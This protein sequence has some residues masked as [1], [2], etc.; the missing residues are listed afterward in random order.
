MQGTD[1]T[2]IGQWLTQLRL[3]RQNRTCTGP[4]FWRPFHFVSLALQMARTGG[5]LALPEEFV[6][7]ASRMGLWQAIGLPTP[8]AVNA[9]D[10]HG[11]FVPLQRLDDA[12]A[13]HDTSVVLAGICKAFGA[14]KETLSSL[15]IS[16][17]EIMDNC[18]AHAEI[19]PGGLQ[20]LACAQSWPRGNLAQ[21]AI[22]DAGV[23]VRASLAGN[24]LLTD[25]LAYENACDLA[26]Q[27]GVTSKPGMGH[28]GYGLALARQLL[29]ANGGMLLVQSSDEW[30]R[31]SGKNVQIGRSLQSWP[32]TL[33][34]LEWDCSKPLRAKDVYQSWPAPS[35]YSDD[36][37]E[38]PL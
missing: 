12:D 13:V 32:G 9:R 36:D 23:G 10:P 26:T 11:K 8:A 37:F 29:Q 2:D 34:L 35:G 17:Q 30:V 20:G 24:P 22:A 18:F 5:N 19:A 28:A 27:F 16:L 14:D 25:Q 3:L 31:V 15:E 4:G 33:I 21:I 38:F 7:Y 1:A 6:G